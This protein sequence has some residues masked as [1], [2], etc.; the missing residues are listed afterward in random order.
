MALLA[1][2]SGNKEDYEHAPTGA[3]QAVCAFVED[4]GTHE[5]EYQG[6]PYQRHQIIICFEL[7]KKMEKGENKDK[8]F[9]L[10][11]F[12]TL[13]LNEKANLSKDLESWF[14]FSF[15]EQQ[16][17][18]GFDLER[19]FSKNCLLSVVKKEKQGGDEYRTINGIMPL[20]KGMQEIKVFNKK[21]P[22][23]IGEYRNRA[24]ENM[25]SEDKV[26]IDDEDLPF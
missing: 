11:K 5:G 19:L 24:L 23:W 2:S 25:S 14:S 7:A 4:V 22:E 21:P 17:N 18:E 12:Y 6:N 8:P 10:S 13:S 1:K 20:P 3:Q 9:M 16:R 26:K 15:T